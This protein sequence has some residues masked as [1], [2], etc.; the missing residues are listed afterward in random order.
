MVVLCQVLSS[1]SIAVYILC[2]TTGIPENYYLMTA[3]TL[4]QGVQLT[5]LRGQDA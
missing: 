1:S 3:G 4:Q 5:S 2:I